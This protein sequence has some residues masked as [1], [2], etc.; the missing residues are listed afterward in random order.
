M[1]DAIAR[2]QRGDRRAF[3][4]IYREQA[5]R[6][7]AL[8]LRLSGDPVRAEEHVQDVFVRAWERLGSFRGDA[9]FS[10]WLHR[11]TINIVLYDR[12]TERR[13]ERR[14]LPTAEVNEQVRSTETAP[15]VRIDLERAVAALPNGARRVFVLYDVEGYRH[16][17]IAEML[18]IATGTSKAHLHRARQLL[19]EALNR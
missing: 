1:T 12:R 9:A 10:T 2:A 11:L 16:T 15:A 5:G 3:E 14:V 6:V 8:C 4:A 17:E 13:R 19:R 18:G 7:Y